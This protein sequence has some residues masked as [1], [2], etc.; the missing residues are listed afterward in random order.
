VVLGLRDRFQAGRI[1]GLADERTISQ[2]AQIR[3]TPNSRG[4]IVIESKEEL[5]RRGV[6]SPDRAA[7]V[8]LAFAKRH[9][10]GPAFIESAFHYLD[11]RSN[12][13]GAV[14]GTAETSCVQPSYDGAFY[15]LAPPKLQC[16]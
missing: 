6:K 10:Q 7:S 2:L 4:Q 13:T 1:T 16:L 15:P 8:M 3:Y 14:A 9:D 12:Q 11:R 5:L